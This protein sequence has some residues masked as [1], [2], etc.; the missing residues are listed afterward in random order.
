V[1]ETEASP[2]A[3]ELREDDAVRRLVSGDWPMEW[4]A[5][6]KF[7]SDD[8]LKAL[9][10]PGLQRSQVL[11]ALL[12]VMQAAREDITMISPYFVPGKQGTKGMV[13]AAKAGK[14]V[15]MLTNSLAANDVAAVHGGYSRYREAL[16]A[17]GVELW[18]LK[19]LGG[20]KAKSS[21]KGSSGASLHTKALSV[22]GQAL[23]V[24]S[25]NLDP[26]STSLNCEQGVLI[27]NAVL[28][29]QFEAL[30]ARQSSGQR[31]WAVQLD[32]GALRWSDGAETFDG[33]PK[34][35]AGRRFQA[36]LARVLRIDSQL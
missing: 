31:A 35:S 11:I 33:D 29:K 32:G 12:P 13:D 3:S 15:R 26:R 4:T 17:G 28:A 20:A 24:G 6:Y 22:D 34:A 14:R 16:V 1:R 5:T 2:Y 25:Y 30:F 8:P 10:E 21:L 36:W 18:E 27:E 7:V 23:F 19:P 9:S